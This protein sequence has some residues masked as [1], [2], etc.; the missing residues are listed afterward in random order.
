MKVRKMIKHVLKDNYVSIIHKR[1]QIFIGTVEE[2]TDEK[3]LNSK[4]KHIYTD[5]FSVPNKFNSCLV[6]GIK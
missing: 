4:I 5:E 3:I 6:I 1:E 2:L